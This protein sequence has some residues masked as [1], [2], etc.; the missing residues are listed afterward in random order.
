MRSGCRVP[1]HSE[2]VFERQEVLS[3]LQVDAVQFRSWVRESLDRLPVEFRRQLQNVEVVI[4]ERPPP[5]LASRFPGLLLGLYQGVPRDRRVVSGVQI[6][7]KIS[8]FRRN[9]IRQCRSGAEVRDRIASTLLHE[10]GHHFGM[11]E[12]QLRKAGY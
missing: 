8:L 10:I 7:D 11:N 5:E 2:P 3:L 1:R 9:I 4:E 12:D 6:P